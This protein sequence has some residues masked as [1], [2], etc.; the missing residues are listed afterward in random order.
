MGIKSPKEDTNTTDYP[1]WFDRNKL[2]NVSY[3]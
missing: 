2:K 3:Y 1:N